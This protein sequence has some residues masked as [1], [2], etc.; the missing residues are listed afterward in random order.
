MHLLGIHTIKMGP[1]IGIAGKM[2][3][4]ETDWNILKSGKRKQNVENT[5]KSGKT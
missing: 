2:A 5:Q 1:L 3:Q 4:R